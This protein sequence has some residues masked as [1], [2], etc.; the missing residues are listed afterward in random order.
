MAA[1]AN[2]A[3]KAG[4]WFRRGRLLIV[5]PDSLGTACPLSGRN[6]TYRPVQIL[7]AGS[8]FDVAS[9][10]THMVSNG[11]LDS[12]ANNQNCRWCAAAKQFDLLRA[13]AVNK[14]LPIGAFRP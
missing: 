12:F 9:E 14:G 10:P 2:F 11:G 7:E 6:S 8:H 1:S 13:D 3:L 4:V 5:S